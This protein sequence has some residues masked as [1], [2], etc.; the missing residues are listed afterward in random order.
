MLFL[1]LMR[2]SFAESL[3]VSVDR[4]HVS[5]VVNE[6]CSSTVSFPRRLQSG[7]S[8]M[9]DLDVD[10]VTSPTPMDA[11]ILNTTAVENAIDQTAVT[12]LLKTFLG[13]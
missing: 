1:S 6:N 10:I 8:A 3:K 7:G 4:V 5:V 2:L 11:T 9:V 13:A 12:V